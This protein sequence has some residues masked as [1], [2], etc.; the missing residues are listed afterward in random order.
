MDLDLEL[1]PSLRGR[2]PRA[3]A[4]FTERELTPADLSAIATERGTKPTALT[5]LR[6]RHHTLARLLAGGA[7]D[8]AA[9][10]ITGYTASR[11]SIL[12]G[13]PA[14]QELVAWYKDQ[15]DEKYFDMHEQLAGLS[16]DALAE[17][18]DRLE[19]DPEAFSTNQLLEILTKTA[20]RVGHG[21]SS[22]T[23]V[24]VNIGIADRMDAARNR[25]KLVNPAPL[26]E[27]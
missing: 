10:A 16:A 20:D 26:L 25:L 1:S 22:K 24:N 8:Q 11:I 15:Q 5:K 13:D 21:P 9:A 7:Q 14:F 4:A 27:G 12:K 19:E 6:D 18:R 3:I 23:D 2:K 17:L